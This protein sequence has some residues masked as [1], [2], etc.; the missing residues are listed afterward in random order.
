MQWKFRHDLQKMNSNLTE[1]YKEIQLLEHE[2]DCRSTIS[3]NEK[4][5][6]ERK[7]FIKML[8]VFNQQLLIARLTSIGK[9]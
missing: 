8:K 4:A 7:I 1:K 6:K 2:A 5:E 9:S 3:L